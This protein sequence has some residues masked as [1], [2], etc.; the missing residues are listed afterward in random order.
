TVTEGI[1]NAVDAEDFVENHL[2]KQIQIVKTCKNNDLRSC[3]I[4]TDANA[5][6]TL[7]EPKRKITMPKKI[8]DLAY[9]ISYAEI[10]D[11]NSTSYGFVMSNGYSVNLF[12]NPN[13]LSD[14]NDNH[15]GPDRVCV[16]AIYDMNGLAGPN[17][18]GKDIGFVTVIYP[19]IN[20]VAVA[21]DVHKQDA[22]EAEFDEADESCKKIDKEYAVPNK[23]ELLAI[24]MNANLLGESTGWYWSSSSDAKG[25]VWYVFF[26]SG[27]RYRVPKAGKMSVH[28]I[29]R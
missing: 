10:L 16:N 29:R 2:R 8:G 23:D 19:D 18:A 4:E 3:G 26:N 14:S 6:T 17:E 28:C 1:G 25:L 9:G 5:I 24:Y 21:F 20:S 11:V 22:E 12:Y 13:C 27:Y 15:C 7:T